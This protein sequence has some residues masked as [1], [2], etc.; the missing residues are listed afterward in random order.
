M[1]PSS[2][3]QVDNEILVDTFLF[4][5]GTI[6]LIESSTAGLKSVCD[7]GSSIVTPFAL[8]SVLL[9]VVRLMAPDQK[10]LTFT[11]SLCR[12]LSAAAGGKYSALGGV[13]IVSNPNKGN[14]RAGR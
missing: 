8:T 4:L 12:P 9:S 13:K 1:F 6:P 11:P 14:S 3:D 2:W 5:G 7:V 10:L